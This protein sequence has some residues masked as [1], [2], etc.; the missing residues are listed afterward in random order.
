M[1]RFFNEDP[2]DQNFLSSNDEEEGYSGEGHT[3]F[4]AFI[5]SEEFMNV[6]SMDLAQM[7]LNQQLL[8]A[9]EEM[10]RKSDWF[11]GLR[12]LRTQTQKIEQFYIKMIEIADRVAQIM[13]QPPKGE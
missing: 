2:D 9:A 4:K 13:E 1:K 10:A 8:I 6:M 11:W 3:E 5:S 12:S 7:Q